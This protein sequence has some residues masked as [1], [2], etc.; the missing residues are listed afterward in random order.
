MQTNFIFS[1][2]ILILSIALHEASHGYAANRLGDPTA[3]LAGRLTLNPLKHLDLFGSVIIPFLTFI[4]GGFIFGWAKPVP[5]NPYNLTDQRWGEAKVAFAGP[6]S[7]LLLA[8]IFGLAIRSGLVSTALL[9]PVSLIVFVNILLAIF[10]LIPIPPLDGSKILFSLLPLKYLSF[11]VFLERYSLI[12]IIILIFFLW[13][14]LFPIISFIF[15]LV[16][17]IPL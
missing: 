13:R 3:R 4:T 8:L 16:T 14:L 9:T 7:N 5:Y 12:L 6:A 11:R 2:V 1:I 10:N 17:G 15:F